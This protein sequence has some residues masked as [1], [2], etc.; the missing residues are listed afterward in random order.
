MAELALDDDQRHAFMGHLDCV[1]VAELVRSE[2]PADSGGGSRSAQ[3]GSGG[4][5]RPVA[6]AGRA[7]DDRKRA[8]RWAA[9]AAY[10]ARLQLLPGPF[11]H[12]DFAPSAAFALADQER[13][14][15]MLEIRLA[16]RKRCLDAETGSPEHG[17]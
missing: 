15:A 8:G 2:A 17:D 5:A 11:V 9:R 1:G 10:R 7:V 4:R 6:S 12:A 13:A 3:P 16:E 14:A